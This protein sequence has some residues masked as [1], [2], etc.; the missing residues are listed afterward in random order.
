[1]LSGTYPLGQD[2]DQDRHRVQKVT[3]CR[4][5]NVES[6]TIGPINRPTSRHESA[7]LTLTMITLNKW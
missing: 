7:F 6:I 2:L 4:A 5:V 3:D 1:M